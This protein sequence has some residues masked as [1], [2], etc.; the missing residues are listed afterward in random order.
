MVST[1]EW[2]LHT[3]LAP[4]DLDHRNVFDAI[5]LLPCRDLEWEIRV[6]NIAVVCDAGSG[7]ELQVRLELDGEAEG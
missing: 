3:T 4:G 1:A 6:E 7:H 2:V 5:S